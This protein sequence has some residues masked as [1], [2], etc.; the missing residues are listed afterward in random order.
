MIYNLC[1]TE[2]VKC[3]KIHY[4]IFQKDEPFIFSNME[5]VFFI[6]QVVE[7]LK[8]VENPEEYPVAMKY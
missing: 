1:N 7:C 8:F 4:E 3:T 6:T 5:N 2:Q